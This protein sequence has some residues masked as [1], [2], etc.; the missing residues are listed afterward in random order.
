M[1]SP[2]E[3][4]CEFIRSQSANLQNV[5]DS[6]SNQQTIS[7]LDTSDT[8]TLGGGTSPLHLFMFLLLAVWGFLYVSGRQ[9]QQEPGKPPSGAPG[10]SAPGEAPAVPAVPAAAPAAAAAEAQGRANS[11]EA[12]ERP[13]EPAGAKRRAPVASPS[14][15]RGA[16][17]TLTEPRG[18]AYCYAASVAPALTCPS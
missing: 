3:C 2:W 6:L 1:S 10:S 9:N 15:L 16:G 14:A 7:D 4:V 18:C 17:A 12:A 13:V 8:L 5:M 11:S